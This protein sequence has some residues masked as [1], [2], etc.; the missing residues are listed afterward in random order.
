MT[1]PTLTALDVPLRMDETGTI[2]IGRTRVILDLVVA[3]FKE[4]DTPE[5]IIER[6]DSLKLAEVYAV[7]AYYLAHQPEL[8]TYLKQRREAAEALRQEIES[9]QAMPNAVR[10][11][12]R[13]SKR[14]GVIRARHDSPAR[15]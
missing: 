14:S 5:Q 8:D 3:A 15:R 1:L 9:N 7:I 13:G 4:G 10:Q 11:C 6:Y 2:R 12:G